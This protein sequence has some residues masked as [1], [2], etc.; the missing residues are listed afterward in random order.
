MNV[1]ALALSTLLSALVLPY[2]ASQTTGPAVAASASTAVPPLVPYTGQVEG[3]TGH[4]SATFLIYKDQQGGE[5]LFA[6]SQTISFDASGHYKVQLGAANPNG[7]PSELFAT[8]EARWLEVQVAGEPAQP[9]V[10]LASVPYALK[11]AEAATLGGLP[12]SAFAL[13]GNRELSN[14]AIHNAGNGVAPDAASTVTTTGGTSNTI[15]KF[16]GSNAIVNSIVYDNGTNVGIGTTSPTATL[17]VNGTAAL[18]GTTTLNGAAVLNATGT[19]T[20]ARAYNSQLLKAY[21]SAYKLLD[22]GGR[23]ASLRM[24]G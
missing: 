7:L 4:A 5:P 15:A 22:Q 23:A 6:E 19:A 18:D 14:L 11:A 2:A 17:T 10:L 13:A 3:R 9:R 21:T 12:A 16:S 20:S 8:G 24:A 1:R